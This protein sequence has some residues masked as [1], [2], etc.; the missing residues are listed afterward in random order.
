MEK[1]A[2]LKER[3]AEE[4]KTIPQIYDEEAAVASAEP[5]TSGRFSFCREVMN[6]MYNQRAK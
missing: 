2:L 6:A 1:R 3:S 4:A 5:S